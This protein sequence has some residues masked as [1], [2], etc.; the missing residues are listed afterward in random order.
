[1]NIVFIKGV[2]GICTRVR[3]FADRYLAARSPRLV[4]G[5][6]SYRSM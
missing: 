2:D 6:G 3:G 4:V 5:I 1:M